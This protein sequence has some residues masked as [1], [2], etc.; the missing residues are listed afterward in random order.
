MGEAPGCDGSLEPR[1]GLTLGY[2]RRHRIH[3]LLLRDVRMSKDVIIVGNGR[4][5]SIA[6]TLAR[7]RGHN[8]TVVSN[9]EH[10]AASRA[11]GCVLAPSWLGSLDP[12]QVDVGM[13]VLRAL[14][15]VH[16]VAF[17]SN[18]LGTVFK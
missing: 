13:S 11:S 7:S 16:D 2:D 17:Q 4:F 6:A 9:L 3:L 5:G 12:R 14:Y 10:L 15:A 8:V 18:I 1:A